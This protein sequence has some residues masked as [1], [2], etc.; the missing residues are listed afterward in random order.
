MTG[1]LK[2][3][4]VPGLTELVAEN[5]EYVNYLY[6]ENLPAATLRFPRLKEVRAV[7]MG[8][9]AEELY[10][11]FPV[12]ETAEYISLRGFVAGYVKNLFLPPS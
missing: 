8:E 3:S 7:N 9:Q 2:I 12:L 1:T 6:M 5:L 11:D 4:S 10:M